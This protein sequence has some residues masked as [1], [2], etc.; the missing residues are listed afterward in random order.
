[1][2]KRGRLEG[3]SIHGATIWLGVCALGAWLPSCSSDDR[4]ADEVP[5]ESARPSGAATPEDPSGT[6]G[7]TGSSGGS[8][9]GFGGGAGSSAYSPGIS[10]DDVAAEAPPSNEGDDFDAPGT[11]PFVMADHDPLS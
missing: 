9:A 11:N 10:A 1:M 6:S 5:A 7:I 3:L 4:S 8:G 2:G